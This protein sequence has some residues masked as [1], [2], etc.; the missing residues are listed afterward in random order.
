MGCTSSVPKPYSAGLASNLAHM[1]A[2]TLQAEAPLPDATA[3]GRG[4][5]AHT[6]PVGE[7]P[8]S[9]RALSPAPPAPARFS[10][11]P[12]AVPAPATVSAAGEVV[13]VEHTFAS[14]WK[15]GKKL[16]EG[17][18]ADVHLCT[19]THDTSRVA[20]VKIMHKGKMST[21]DKS[22]AK[23][24]VDIMRKLHHP[25]IVQFLDFF[26]E[27]GQLFVIL[28]Y[29]EGGELFD[30]VLKKEHYS[31]KEARDTVYVF[32][33]ALKHMHDK[34]IVHRDLK[35]ENLLMANEKD[36]ADIKIADFGLSI[37]DN[38]GKLSE[39]CGSPSYMAPELM[40][41]MSYGK[42]VDMWAL[43]VITYIL[44][45]GYPPFDQ[46]DEASVLAGRFEFHPDCWEHVH[47]ECKQFIRGLLQVD[48]KKRLNCEQAL[49]DPWIVTAAAD[50]A[51]RN[52]QKSLAKFKDFHGRRKLKG[53]V[54]GI[55]A[56]NRLRGS[57]KG[58]DTAAP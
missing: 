22:G 5:S 27:G 3:P 24:E 45:G 32:L 55:I 48:P 56:M 35:P 47:D 43:G 38:E 49:R 31:E 33:S 28:E 44:L 57:L 6:N 9:E 8:S 39:V 40:R 1:K 18:F 16:G 52:L 29:L 50:L 19:S 12:L 23:R 58:S 17:A 10:L 11:K 13:Y 34:N 41:G 54:K 15:K 53:A 7:A 25:N 21:G 36:D 30:R 2:E 4:D 42:P 20:A 14:R 37:E 26:D 46:N 51:G